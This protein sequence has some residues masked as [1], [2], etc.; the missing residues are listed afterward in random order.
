MDSSLLIHR[1]QFGFTISFHYLFPQLTLGLGPL[2]V[3]L[4]T[5]ALK[6]NDERY[7]D[8][9]R[10]WARI[11]S[12]NFVIGVV[13]GIPMEFQFG[14]NWS[15]FSR[16]RGGTLQGATAVAAE[17]QRRKRQCRMES[18]KIDWG[19]KNHEFGT[20]YDTRISLWHHPTDPFQLPLSSAGPPVPQRW[21]ARPGF[22]FWTRDLGRREQMAEGGP[23][24]NRSA[25]L[26]A[27]S[28]E[29]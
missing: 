2:I 13:T 15:H 19:A 10:F 18:V 29:R 28:L 7:D 24:R 3:I 25:E 26:L 5:L 16:L 4:K 8:A 21:I 20:G 27:S 1:L 14:T 9:A 17:E 6:T 12:I 11:F 22:F 23:Y